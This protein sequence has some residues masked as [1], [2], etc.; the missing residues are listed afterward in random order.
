MFN[1]ETIKI[2]PFSVF[3]A[4]GENGPHSGDSAG[5]HENVLKFEAPLHILPRETQPGSFEL[6]PY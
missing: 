5:F 3:S 2:T 6:L 4:R 1:R